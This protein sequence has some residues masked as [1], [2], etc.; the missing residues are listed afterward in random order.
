MVHFL[1][2]LS[3]VALPYFYDKH[4]MLSVPYE[5]NSISTAMHAQNE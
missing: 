3:D 2:R 5:G 4:V 1:V